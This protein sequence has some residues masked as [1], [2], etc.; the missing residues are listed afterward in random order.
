MKTIGLIGGISWQSTIVYYRVIN[1]R[2]N[3]LLGGSHSARVLLNSVDFDEIALMQH[4]GRWE[5]FRELL[6]GV[7]NS[8][9]RGGA[10]FFLI[11]ANTPHIVAD[12]V[13]QAVGIPL[14]HIGDATGAAIQQAGMKKVGLLGTRYTMEED[15]LKGRL[16]DKFGIEAFVP[17]KEDRDIVHRV[18]YDELV[19]GVIRD[20]S[21]ADYLKIIE[22]LTA[23][24]AEGII[25]GCTEIPLLVTPNDTDAVLFDTTSLHAESAVDLGLNRVD[26]AA[27]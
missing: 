27:V 16:K 20:Q 12:S 24:G 8:L 23:E 7:A 22:K 1:Q 5:E 14:V 6:I 3:E 19:K 25:L 10:D 9:E 21:R 4:E 13:E 17:E 18:I 15:F 11:C 26:V 2:T